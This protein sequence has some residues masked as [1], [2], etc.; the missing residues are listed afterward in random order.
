MDFKNNFARP[1][2][3]LSACLDSE[4]VRYNGEILHNDLVQQLKK[5][6]DFIKVCPEVSIGLGVPRDPIRIY[7]SDDVFRIFQTKT[8]L[9]LTEKMQ[10]FSAR[11][12]DDLKEV[13][14]F[15]LK[16]KSPSCGY[17]GTKIYRDKNARDIIKIGTGLFAQ[18][19]KEKFPYKPVED[20][21]RLKN[22]GIRHNFL[23]KVF[24]FAEC[25]NLEKK[26]SS[27]SQLVDFHAR[28]KYLLMLYNQGKMAKLGKIVA[29]YKKG[30]LEKTMRDYAGIF[31]T[32][33][34]RNPGI[35]KQINVI[36]H[37]YGYFSNR[38]NPAEKRH[39]LS[40]LKKYQQEKIHLGTLLELMKSFVFR[41]D[42]KYLLSQKYFNP[43]P[44]ELQIKNP[45]E[46]NLP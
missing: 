5:F 30:S 45:R 40:L 37:I 44:E 42:V 15:I 1:I 31:Y 7:M 4:P 38:L 12:L 32:A 11:F 43:Y 19:V 26:I 27:I 29:N 25:G 3:V 9:D 46:K 10:E 2:I 35:K 33:F 6:V 21:L 41:F 22:V 28:H 24:A 8:N 16:G 18:I 39:F 14:G 13:D 20:E 23:T 36:Q 17:S 34:E